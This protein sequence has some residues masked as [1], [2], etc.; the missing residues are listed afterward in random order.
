MNTRISLILTLIFMFTSAL[1]NKPFA[2]TQTWQTPQGAQVIFYQAREVPMLDIIVAFAAGSA[3][4]GQQWGLS[5]LTQSL[6]DQGSAGLDA[7]AIADKFAALGAQYGGMSTRDLMLLSMRTLVEPE[8]LKQAVETLSLVI[9]HPDF[10]NEAFLQEKNQQLM[11]TIQSRESPDQLAENTFYQMLYGQHPYAHPINGDDK[12]VRALK[13]DDVHRFYHQY[14]VSK[15]AYIVLVGDIESTTAHQIAERITHDLAPGTH[16]AATPRATPLVSDV[17]VE[18]PHAASQTVVRLGQLGITHQNK[19]FFPLQVGSYILGGG[20]LV[21]RLAEELREKRG[22]TYGVMSQFSPM[23]GQGPFM[24]SFSTKKTQTKNALAITRETLDAYLK[25]GPNE[26]E[27]IAAKQYLVGSFPISMSSNRSIAEMLL[28]IAFYKLPADF[29]TSYVVHV[30]AV[31]TSDIHQA[32]QRQINP[33]K[34]LQVT[35]GTL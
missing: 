16:A 21:S 32:F 26:Q 10:S 11:S 14:I 28:K 30:N 2:T 19:D 35:V 25:S 1:A 9:S 18:I 31:T 34:L 6:L 27:L 20:S 7:S 24:I 12:S 15:N 3:H 17:S 22:L 5:A 8:T 29:L 23:P 4:D 33:D 13:I